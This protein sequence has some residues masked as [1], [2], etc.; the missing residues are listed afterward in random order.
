MVFLCRQCAVYSILHRVRSKAPVKRSHIIFVSTLR[1]YVEAVW[2]PLNNVEEKNHNLFPQCWEVLWHV[3]KSLSQYLLNISFV[4][5]MLKP[6][7][8]LPDAL[9]ALS[10][11][12]STLFSVPA[13]RISLVKHLLRGCWS[14]LTRVSTSLNMTHWENVETIWLGLYM[15][16]VFFPGGLCQLCC[17][18]TVLSVTWT[19]LTGIAP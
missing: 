2:H 10:Q 4:L 7:D 12:L 16:F 11:L 6:F 13:S 14:R 8:T 17:I 15:H 19:T 1:A 18:V 5:E 3:E 9:R